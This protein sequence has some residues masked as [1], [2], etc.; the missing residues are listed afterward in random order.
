MEIVGSH[1]LVAAFGEGD[2]TVAPARA[3][4]LQIVGRCGGELAGEGGARRSGALELGV[5][6]RGRRRRH[7]QR[8]RRAA[9][10]RP[11][12]EGGASDLP[13][14][15]GGAIGV[16]T[17]A[18]ERARRL[19]DPLQ[20]ATLLNPHR[21]CNTAKPPLTSYPRP[22]ALQRAP[23]DETYR[24]GASPNVGFELPDVGIKLAGWQP[25]VQLPRL[26][27]RNHEDHPDCGR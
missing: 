24:A 21:P 19:A 12:P 15:P 4:M 16:V 25:L 18:A 8:L 26:K 27:A 13:F 17:R 11:E 1:K 9:P 23:E 10:G 14:T 3:A 6:L 2:E 22:A 7:G 20:K 5:H